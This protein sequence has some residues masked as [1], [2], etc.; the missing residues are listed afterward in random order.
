V[1]ENLKPKVTR[2]SIR[3]DQ[4][5]TV[6][7]S[8]YGSNLDAAGFNLTFLYRH[9]PALAQEVLDL[10]RRVAKVEETVAGTPRSLAAR[11]PD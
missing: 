6:S 11:R 4:V 1:R 5:A 2:L 3:D 10:L 8:L 7:S 9:D